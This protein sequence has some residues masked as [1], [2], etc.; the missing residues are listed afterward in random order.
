MNKNMIPN[1]FTFANLS[2]GILAILFTL[3]DKPV[4]AAIFIV[5]AALIDRYDGRVARKFDASSPL[6]KELDSLADLVSFGAAPAVLAWGTFLN[7]FGFIGYLITII[8]PICGAYRLA[9]FNV[10]SF[11]NVFTGVPI[12]VA[13]AIAAIDIIIFS[14]MPHRI[15]SS[16]LLLLLSYLMVS[17][18]EF[19]KF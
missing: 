19:K 2:C 14:F 17:N 7:N 6:G 11:N 12:T 13:G 3:T 16:I 18:V 8:Y 15:I 1:L 10:S 5:T 9:R 4:A